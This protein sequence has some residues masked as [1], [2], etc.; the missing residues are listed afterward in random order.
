M[1]TAD[2]IARSPLFGSLPQED[3]ERLA[4]TA[5]SRSF[6]KDEAIFSE[7]DRAEGFYLLTGGRAK[8]YML[9]PAGREQILHIVSAGEIFGE[10][11]V[12]AGRKYPAFA[13]A[14]AESRAVFFPA[15]RFRAQ[16]A[17]NPELALHMLGAMAGHLR[18]FA[19]LVEQLSL[20]DV[21]ARLAEYLLDAP[22]DG[23]GRVSLS[24]TKRELA[25]QL[26]TQPETLS[27]ALGAL[28]AGGLI[29]MDGSSIRIAEPQGLEGIA[30][31]EA[32]S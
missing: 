6:A 10:A 24:T 5:V 23:E 16:I 25:A 1:S 32:D 15:D 7:G 26:G 21:R 3:I 18:R 11:A 12:F 13:R 22:A 30:G 29:E 20:R 4:G 14:L 17:A 27:R 31:G 2:E 19:R 8:I 9:S 28:Q